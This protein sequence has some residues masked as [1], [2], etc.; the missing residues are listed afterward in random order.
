MIAG[1]SI[2]LVYQYFTNHNLQVVIFIRILVLPLIERPVIMNH[3]IMIHQKLLCVHVHV[4]NI[5]MK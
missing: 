2:F 1:L 5:K 3:S 4:Q